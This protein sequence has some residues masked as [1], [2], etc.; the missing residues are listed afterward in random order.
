MTTRKVLRPADRSDATALAVLT[1][2]AGEGMPF[3]A[4]SGMAEEHQSPLEIGRSRAARD[5]GGFSY[6]N[7]SVLEIEDEIAGMVLSYQLD[8]PYEIGDLEAMP[9]PFRPLVELEAIVP[10]SWYVSALATFEEFNDRDNFQTLM[11][12]AEKKAYSVSAKEISFICSEKNE[13]ACFLCQTTG[14]SERSR[15]PMISFPGER[16]E[17]NWLL[18]VKSLQ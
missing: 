4:W 10:G 11:E 17:G 1:D 12:K 5:E 3:W 9:E 18:F 7:A 15:R 6:R 16:C 8:D 14:F 2:I 13:E